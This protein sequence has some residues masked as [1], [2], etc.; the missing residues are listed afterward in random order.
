MNIVNIRSPYFITV[1]IA[2]QVGSKIEL[3]IWNEG[4]TEP[5]TPT[6]TFTK[7]IAQRTDYNIS[8]FVKEYIDNSISYVGSPTA[9]NVKNWTRFKV[10]RYKETSI[11]VY[12][13]LNT[14]NYMAVNGY[15]LFENGYNYNA[16]DV[17]LQGTNITTYYDRLNTNY[18]YIELLL[19]TTLGTTV[20]A[21]YTAGVTTVIVDV[22]LAAAA[23]GQYNFKVPMTTNNINFANGNKLDIFYNSL[24][25]KTFT[26]EPIEEGKYSPVVCH[27][28]NRFGGAQFL[29]FF[30]AKTNTIDVKGTSYKLLSDSVDY[31]ISKGQSKRFNINGSQT[32]KL[33]TGWVDENYSELITDLFLSETVLLDGK[34]VEVKTQNSVLKT[35]LKDKNINYEIE[36]Q[37]AFNLINDVV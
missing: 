9:N 27:F 33:N 34:P 16:I 20:K 29:T 6:Y 30:K 35:Y 11:G 7:R 15:T 2:L 17:V 22:L 5:V 1:D 31:N 14:V 28:I 19:D 13:F 10:K 25:I 26:I 12:S 32:I 37:Y 8:N 3:F 24:S 4:T 18:P 36:F 23:T 21:Y